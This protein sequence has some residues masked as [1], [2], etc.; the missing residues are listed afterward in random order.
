MISS[1][2]SML[3]GAE[4]AGRVTNRTA[5][6]DMS[7]TECASLAHP[8]SVADLKSRDP[9]DSAAHPTSGVWRRTFVHVIQS[10]PG[11]KVQP[12]PGVMFRNRSPFQH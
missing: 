10:R 4:F 1:A 7:V 8:F 9:T 3:Y 5:H 11:G 12:H 2:S 6:S